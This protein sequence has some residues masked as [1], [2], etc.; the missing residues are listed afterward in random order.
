MPQVYEL[1]GN[2]LSFLMLSH[3]FVY[4]Y[5]NFYTRRSFGIVGRRLMAQNASGQVCDFLK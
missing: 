1:R 4:N 5:S 3:H 2:L